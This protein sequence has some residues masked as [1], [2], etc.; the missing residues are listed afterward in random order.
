[1]HIFLGLKQQKTLGTQEMKSKRETLF[2]FAPAKP[3]RSQQ[4]GMGVNPE[5]MSI[6]A[7]S[8]VQLTCAARE[9]A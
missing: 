9:A 7:F 8:A 4:A 2:L 3:H 1:M 6:F 5:R